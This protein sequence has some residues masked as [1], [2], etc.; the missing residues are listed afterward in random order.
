MQQR[1]VGRGTAGE[2]ADGRRAQRQSGTVGTAGQEIGFA[3]TPMKGKP[4]A[5][6]AAARDGGRHISPAS[7]AGGD[8]LHI[9][10]VVVG[11]VRASVIPGR[12]RRR[13]DDGENFAGSG[14]VVADMSSVVVAGWT[15]DGETRHVTIVVVTVVVDPVCG[16]VAVV[17]GAAAE[18]G[19]AD[20]ARGVVAAAAQ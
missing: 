18:M 3:G 10:R 15:D 11:I 12:R 1:S 17:V 19:V 13:G 8:H 2:T 5:E 9:I 7:V 14:F 6:N 20:D 16:V 4:N